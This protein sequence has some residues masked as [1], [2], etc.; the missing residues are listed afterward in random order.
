ML[1]SQLR[2][3]G[4]TGAITLEAIDGV[5]GDAAALDAAA[6]VDWNL[7]QKKRTRKNPGR[8]FITPVLVC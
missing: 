6:A 4:I 5:G 8:R 2:L 3:S 7:H 1:Q